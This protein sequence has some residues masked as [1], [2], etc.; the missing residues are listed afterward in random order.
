MLIALTQVNLRWKNYFCGAPSAACFL[1]TATF[2]NRR[3]ASLKVRMI[4]AMPRRARKRWRISRRRGDA[5]RPRPTTS[6]SIWRDNPPARRSTRA[7]IA[8]VYTLPKPCSLSFC[9]ARASLDIILF[10]PR[11]RVRENRCRPIP[12]FSG[13]RRQAPAPRCRWEPIPVPVLRRRRIMG[14]AAQ[15]QLHRDR[16]VFVVNLTAHLQNHSHRRCHPLQKLLALPLGQRRRHAH[17]D[18]KLVVV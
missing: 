17:D 2:S 10:T 12:K 18:F 14:Q 3:D 15:G 5:A 16:N 9:G 1:S 11:E 6:R 8:D 4:K 13:P 7:K